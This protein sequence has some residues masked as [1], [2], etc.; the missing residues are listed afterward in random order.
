L[1]ATGQPQGW[2]DGYKWPPA[3]CAGLWANAAPTEFP[4]NYWGASF[5]SI[6][7]LGEFVQAKSPAPVRRWFDFQ[8]Q[9]SAILAAANVN[10]ELKE[11]E[12]LIEYRA[13]VMTE[14]LKERGNIWDYWRGIL[15]CNSSSAPRTYELMQIA[16]LVGQFQVMH[17]KAI[18]KRPRPSQYSPSLL[19]VIDPP[20]H[21]SFPSGHATESHLIA[22]CLAQVMP[23][24]ASTPATPATTGVPIPD[25][26]PLQRMAQRIARNREVIG[27][28]Y[29]SDSLAGKT[30]AEESFKIL[31]EC[32]SI[33]DRVGHPGLITQAKA[34]W[35]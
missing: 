21:A 20:G 11:L 2:W 7:V 17:Y 9:L 13:G 6:V 28:H 29:P 25:S 12:A 31:M 15:M 3:D 4:R 32:P 16:Q 10:N 22:L 30:L 26:S 14:A 1:D 24:A 23:A 27:V 34:E 35:L 18:F 5:Y 8:S 33:K 19:P